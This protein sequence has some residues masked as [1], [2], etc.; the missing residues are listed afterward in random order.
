M[1]FGM[2]TMRLETTTQEYSNTQTCAFFMLNLT[3]NMANTNDYKQ[4]VT[5]TRYNNKNKNK[6]L[7]KWN[8]L[9][10]GSNKVLKV[11]SIWNIIERYHE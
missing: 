3:K 9:Y 1:G 4:I 8:L 11:L 2:L 5:I 10:T 6:S 7:Q